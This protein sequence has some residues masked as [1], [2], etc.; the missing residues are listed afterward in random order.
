MKRYYSRKVR[1]KDIIKCF[2]IN[3]SK[4]RYAEL[5]EDEHQ[6]LENTLLL[7]VEG[8]RNIITAEQELG[9]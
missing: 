3:Y 1:P 7:I 5:N 6:Y 8:K 9:L 4:A 2:E